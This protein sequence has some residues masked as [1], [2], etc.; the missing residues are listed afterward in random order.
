M[1][2]SERDLLMARVIA[3][4]KLPLAE[5]RE[6]LEG[7]LLEFVE[8]AWTSIDPA[9]FAKSWAISALAEHLEAVTRGR[10][11]ASLLT[12]RRERV[13]LAWRAC[14]G[15]RGLGHALSSLT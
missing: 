9:P 11:A 13:R 2:L 8:A 5:E 12:T 7:S 4:A 15:R 10:F 14:V 1:Q 3:R 6:R